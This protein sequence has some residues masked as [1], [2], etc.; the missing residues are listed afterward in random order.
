MKGIPDRR[1]IWE[2]LNGVSLRMPEIIEKTGIPARMCQRL[3]W[4]MK[5]EGF[6]CQRQPRRFERAS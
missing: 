4:E 2:A 3:V 1:V 5:K 6:L